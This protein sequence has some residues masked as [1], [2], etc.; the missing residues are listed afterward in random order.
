MLNAET[1]LPGT[2]SSLPAPADGFQPP[3]GAGEPA[4]APVRLAGLDGLRAVAALCVVVMH[5]GAIWPNAPRIIGAAYLSVDFFFLLS[6]FVMARTYEERLRDGR[7]SAARFLVA[8]YRRLWPTMAWGA[9]F[10]LPFLWRD[11]PD[12]PTFLGA[13]LPNL[14]LLPSFATPVL[15]ALNTPAW[16]VF[17]ELVANLAHGLVLHQLR[18]A[19]LAVAAV[20]SLVAVAACARHWGNLD[21]GSQADTMA[22]GFARVAFSYALGILLWRW[23][24]NRAPIGIPAALAFAAMPVLFIAAST[25]PFEGA[26]FDLAFVAVGAP[27]V[28]WGGLNMRIASSGLG[29]M[30]RVAGAMSF[31]LY[32]VHYPVL[33]AAEAVRLP[34]WLGPAVAIAAAAVVTRATGGFY[35]LKHR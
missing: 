20:V 32:A 9:A 6:G 22:G 25:V 8:R 7:L 34:L 18:R 1:A 11:N 31:P 15:F 14:L 28:L 33:L 3:V 2:S 23:H 17:F 24:G 19:A 30:C 21:L 16:S 5:V 12:L 13:S 10:S 29:W 35:P 4:D 27:L 26:A